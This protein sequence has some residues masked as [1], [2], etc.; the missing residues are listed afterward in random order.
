MVDLG[1]GCWREFSILSPLVIDCEGQ[2]VLL[3]LSFER[4]S[5]PPVYNGGVAAYV[6]ATAMPAGRTPGW[7]LE[8]L[9]NYA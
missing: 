8:E 3:T 5:A 4:L 6:A 9:P 1:E 7:E 2:K